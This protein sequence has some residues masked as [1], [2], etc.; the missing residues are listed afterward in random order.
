MLS[1]KRRQLMDQTQNARG[2]LD[3]PDELLDEVIG[4]AHADNGSFTRDLITVSITC[5]RLRKA[6]M[7]ILFR[8]ISIRATGRSIDKHTVSILLN[9]DHAP[10]GIAQ[11]VKHIRSDDCVLNWVPPN[12]AMSIAE[13]QIPGTLRSGLRS[14]VNLK[15]IRSVIP[16]VQYICCL[17]CSAALGVS[18]AHYSLSYHESSQQSPST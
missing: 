7:P 15:T 8:T 2:L 1:L 14:L 12:G 18:V 11:Q 4:F 6:C 9:L 10:Q 17:I 5:S 13:E 16:L 3:L